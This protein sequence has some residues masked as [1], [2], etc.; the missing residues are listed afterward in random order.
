MGNFNFG[1][2]NTNPL[3]SGNGYANMLLGVVTSYQEVTN[4]IAWNVGHWETDAYAQD[5]WRVN[6]RLTLDY[7]LRV[8]HNGS[9][10]EANE[11]TAAFYPELYDPA[12]A[13]RLYRPICTTG[14]Q[15]NAACP[16]ANQAAIDPANPT[17]TVPFQLAGVVVPGSGTLLNGIK[18]GGRNNDGKARRLPTG[19]VGTALRH[20]VGRARRPQGCPPGV[21]R[22]VLRLPPR[23]RRLVHRCPSGV[24]Q[25]VGQQPDDGSALVLLAGRLADLLSEPGWSRLSHRGRQTVQSSG[26]LQG[27]RRVPARHRFQHHGRGGV[28]RQLHAQRHAQLQRRHAA[29]VQCSRIRTTSSIRRC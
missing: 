26:L 21:G 15:G 9:W 2:S 22:N 24:L 1:S 18:A 16:S 23:R 13:V 7:G 27:E 6:S 12:K 28:R 3:D 17:V 14:A 4:R 20:G 5:S 10:Y 11:M 29:V 8:T 19:A 25:P